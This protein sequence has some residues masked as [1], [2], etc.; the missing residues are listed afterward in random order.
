MA[1]GACRVLGAEV[2]LGVTGVAGPD[3]QDGRPPGTVVVGV[4]VPGHEAEA[5]ELRLPG[6]RDRVRQ[7]ATITALDVLRRRLLAG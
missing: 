4:A 7:Y 1:A 3:E 6:D 2:G 5:V